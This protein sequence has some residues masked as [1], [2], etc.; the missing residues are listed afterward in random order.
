ME[1]MVKKRRAFLSLALL[2]LVILG[3]EELCFIN[4]R[5]GSPFGLWSTLIRYYCIYVHFFQ[6]L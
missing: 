3:L 1:K 6:K 5:Q 2:T 4:Y